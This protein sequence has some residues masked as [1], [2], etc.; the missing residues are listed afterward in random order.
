[1]IFPC[2]LFTTNRITVADGQNPTAPIYYSVLVIDFA[3]EV[4]FSDNLVHGSSKV[5]IPCDHFSW[6]FSHIGRAVLVV[7]MAS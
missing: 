2:A 4:T 5:S 7:T 1:M 6:A 3:V